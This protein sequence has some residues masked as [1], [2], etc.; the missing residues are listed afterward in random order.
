VLEK[1]LVVTT[2]VM[3]GDGDIMAVKALVVENV[4]PGQEIVKEASGD[5][6]KI[7]FLRNVMVA[8]PLEDVVNLEEG[9]I[10]EIVH[11]PPIPNLLVLGLVEILL[12]LV[13]VE[14]DQGL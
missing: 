8:A 5:I 14:V 12:S 1:D 9:R 13:R 4:D 3:I 11:D 10:G 7:V 2:E 6:H